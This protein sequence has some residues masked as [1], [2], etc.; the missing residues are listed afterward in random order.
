MDVLKRRAAA[1]FF[2]IS[3]D[4]SNGDGVGGVGVSDGGVGGAAPPRVRCSDAEV[5]T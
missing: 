5:G 1:Q 2:V 4:D 3:D